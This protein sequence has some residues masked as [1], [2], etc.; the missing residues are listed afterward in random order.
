MP[1]F[2]SPGVYTIEK[3]LSEY[4]A[5][6]NSSVVGIVGFASKGPTNKATLI[7]DPAA[8]VRTF[9]PPSE[10]IAGQGLE[11]GLEILETTNSI[12]F[13]RAITDAS[14]IQASAEV[15]LGTCP[16]IAVS[17]VYFGNVL[18]SGIG[19]SG[20]PV[21]FKV[22]VYDNN[23]TAQFVS[24][25]QITM[26]SSLAGSMSTADKN[27]SGEL[28]AFKSA[29]GGTLDGEK[30]GAYFAD[31]QP[32]APYLVTP[33]AGSGA[34][35]AVEAFSDAAY[36]T[37]LP[38][39]HPITPEA[40][41][42]GGG[43]WGPVLPGG[44]AAGGVSAV[45]SYGSTFSTLSTGMGGDTPATYNRFEG[46][47]LFQ[48][49][50]PG[51]GYNLGTTPGGSTSGNSVQVGALGSPFTTLTVNQDGSLD[52]TYKTG[53]VASGGYNLYEQFSRSNAATNLKSDIVIANAVSGNLSSTITPALID[54]F[55]D[56]INTIGW[57]LSGTYG[58]FTY[59]TDG[60]ADN[61]FTSSVSGEASFNS[62]DYSRF[63]KMVGGTYG[64]GGGTNGDTT[65]TADQ[66][67]ALIGTTTAAGKKTGMQALDD[68]LL[69]ISVGIVPGIT[70][71]NTQ[72]ALIGLA[73]STQNFLSVVSPPYG[74]GGTQDAIAWGNGQ[75]VYRSAAINTSYAA[76]FWPW[77]KV[78]SSFDSKDRWYDP[79]IFGVRQ[80]TYTDNVADPWFA[81]AGYRRG[82]LTKPV[83]VEVTL[84]QGDRDSLYSGGNT[85]NPIV[86]FPQ[87]GI[88]IWGQRTMQKN[89]TAL[90][91]INIR[92]M[93]IFIRKM[94][95]A[96]TR[97]FVFEPNDPF[98]WDAIVG[99]ISPALA[100]IK[101]RRGITEFKVVCDET[102]NTPVRVDRNEL[103]CKILIK[104]TK[105][106][107]ILV[108]ELNL[109][110]QGATLS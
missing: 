41:V 66:D 3:D 59:S 50:Y 56:S 15:P 101:N 99:V 11:G 83:D 57:V 93:M 74:I 102:T 64:L 76:S 47:V 27:A 5:T 16:A 1:S 92:R 90:D 69:N 2:V 43:A 44:D 68:D 45:R 33:F 98:T 67:T 7:T 82:R 96:S 55:A 105:T 84:N 61:S 65:T 75:S 37:G 32:R 10:D 107:E 97:T 21:Y 58:G 100:D 72:N 20:S 38:I 14:S 36:T 35:I 51:G 31:S 25:K 46:G 89:P 79:A 28:V 52:E 80:M 9:G 88:T 6:I 17:S 18:N 53:F 77:V 73:E 22:Q 71:Q 91:R 40:A 104:P 109:T 94:V 78:F 54:N 23:G 42:S 19:V 4:P 86:N 48:S 24:K 30:I 110:S 108:F 87:Q 13:I 26:T 81:P 49:L 85:I 62:S 103:W 39:L 12:Y 70:N 29:W 60:D 8:L 95:L 63:I 34:S 106:A